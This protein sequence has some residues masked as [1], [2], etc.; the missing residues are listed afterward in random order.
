MVPLTARHQPQKKAG[1]GA[2]LPDAAHGTRTVAP[3]AQH[4]VSPA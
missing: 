4:S 1:A 3:H 2:P